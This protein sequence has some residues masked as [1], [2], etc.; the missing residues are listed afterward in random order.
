MVRAVLD[1]G[2][3]AADVRTDEER[4]ARLGVRQVPTFVINGTP[5]VSG[6]PGPAGLQALPT[7][8]AVR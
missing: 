2:A 7:S 1:T 3:Y 8:P 6:A 4:A 5:V